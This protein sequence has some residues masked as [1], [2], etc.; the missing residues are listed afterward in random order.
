MNRKQ[1]RAMARGRVDPKQ[2]VRIGI[3]AHKQGRL[4]EAEKIY[5]SVLE[6]VNHPDALHFLGVLRHRQG[7]GKAGLELVKQS[8]VI[9][10][11]NIDAWNNLGNIHKELDQLNE[12]AECYRKVLELNSENWHALNNLGTV[13]KGLGKYNGAIEMFQQALGG[14][15]E[16]PDIYQ[17]LSNCYRKMDQF[18]DAINCYWKAIQLRPYDAEDYCYLRNVLY[19]AGQKEKLMKRLVDEWLERDSSDE[20][21]LH[22]RATFDPDI[23]PDRAGDQYVRTT[24]DQFANSFDAI[25]KTLDYR[26]AKLVS[27]LINERFSSLPDKPMTLDAGCGT[28][29]CGPLIKANVSRLDGVDISP[30]MLEKAL[31][32]GVYNEL[33]E[34]ELTG[35]IVAQSSAYD[36]I[37]AADTLVYFGNL[38]PVFQAISNALRRGGILIFTV[39]ESQR[40]ETFELALH[41][42]YCHSKGYIQETLKNSGF[43]VIS[44]GTVVLRRELGEEVPGFLV[45]AV[46]IQ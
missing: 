38:E 31:S 45:E 35:F 14:M 17:N 11:E 26:A 36:L 32:R 6:I 30:A 24:F 5:R 39:E 16:N 3:E 46:P 29:L 9:D 22:L 33:I 20:T 23:V 34:A 25:L 40:T 19:A 15:P 42:R 2:M 27:G 12:A 4:D 18:G 13:L 28:G 7:D 10:A 8:L 1:R 41:G 43:S 21:A 44:W 37:F